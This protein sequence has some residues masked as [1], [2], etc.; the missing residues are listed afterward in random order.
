MNLVAYARLIHK[1]INSAHR[2]AKNP[3]FNAGMSY[4]PFARP[5]YNTVVWV[6]QEEAIDG[7]SNR[8]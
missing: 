2:K 8:E 6:E 4:N 7:K 1:K 5:V 3:F